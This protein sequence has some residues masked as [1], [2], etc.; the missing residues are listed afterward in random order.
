[1]SIFFHYGNWRR[2]IRRCPVTTVIVLINTVMFLL[3]II[4]GGFNSITL[5]KLGA[6]YPPLVT[7]AHEYYRLL[8]AT[9]LHGSVFH[10]LSNILFGIIIISAGL[11]KLIGSWRFLI[12]YIASGIL[13]SIV[14]TLVGGNSITVGASGS[15]FG[16]MGTF[17]IIIVYKTHL[18][19]YQDQDYVKKL[20]LI[21]LIFT[22]LGPNIS[23]PGHLGGLLGGL[24]TGAIVLNVRNRDF[25][26]RY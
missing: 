10:F 17:L 16:V 13:S 24:I 18:L 26:Y 9:F 25:Y 7:E 23:I 19:T 3:T 8:T 15:I 14:V 21:N 11:E 12:V 6:L 22:F 4:K 2:I 5:I 20:L 1:M